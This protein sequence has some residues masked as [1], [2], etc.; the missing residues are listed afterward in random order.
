MFN[1]L[2]AVSVSVSSQ[3][4][5]QNKKENVLDNDFTT[6][7]TGMAH[8][9]YA[10]IDLGEVKAI[11]GVALAF[12]KGYER[13]YYFD[14]YVSQDGEN[15]Q[16]AYL[17]GQSSGTTEDLEAYAFDS[18][19]NARYVKC[20]GFGNSVPSVSNVNINMLEFRALTAK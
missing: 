20:V 9:E 13:E 2:G 11:D 17:K 12:W 5:P 3:P 10:V 16:E 4:E 14:I 8:G 15:W 19:M 7:W 1:Q 6:R 18:K